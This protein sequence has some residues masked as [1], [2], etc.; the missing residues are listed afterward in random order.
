ML[1]E[2]VEVVMRLQ[3]AF[4]VDI[5]LLATGRTLSGAGERFD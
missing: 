3:P 4:D 2:K 5:L 1:Q